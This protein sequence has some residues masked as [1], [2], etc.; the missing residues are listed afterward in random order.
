MGHLNKIHAPI[1]SPIA[2]KLYAALKLHI[3]NKMGE[4]NADA[5]LLEDDEIAE[6]AKVAS[7]IRIID[8]NARHKKE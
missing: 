6:I 8:A 5:S 3:D 7:R 1:H 2:R 4:M